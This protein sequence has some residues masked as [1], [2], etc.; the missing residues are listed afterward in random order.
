MDL[1]HHPP[2]G[3]ASLGREIVSALAG[4][5]TP[6]A[7]AQAERNGIAEVTLFHP[8]ESRSVRRERLSAEGGPTPHQPRVA[9]GRSGLCHVA[10][11]AWLGSQ[12]HVQLRSFEGPSTCT[13]GSG[14]ELVRR[15]EGMVFPP[16]VVD[17]GDTVCVVW[18]EEV[19][20]RF[21]IYSSDSHRMVPGLGGALT[22][23]FATELTPEAVL[24]AYRRRRLIATSGSRMLIDFRVGDHFVGEDGAVTGAP[25]VI[26]RVQAPREIEQVD[27]VRDG[28]VIRRLTPGADTIDLDFDDESASVGSHFYF[29]RVKLVGDPSFN[30]GTENMQEY[31]AFQINGRYAGNWA[32]ADGCFGWSS[33]IWIER[34][35]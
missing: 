33:P 5:G 11:N 1:F 31:R 28:Q 4:D 16:A 14:P 7:V 35:K 10:W 13:A 27:V 23:V 8:D 12:W 2:V 24:D 20:G 25:R 21:G 18:A 19:G 26:G 17:D 34:E 32:R 6:V 15:S 22:G 30:I 29:L 9:R 3:A